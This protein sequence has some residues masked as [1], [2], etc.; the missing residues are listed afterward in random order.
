MKNSFHAL[1][2]ILLVKGAL[3]DLLNQNV[4]TNVFTDGI[5]Y[6]IESFLFV[7]VTM[8]K[9][10]GYL[11]KVASCEST[12]NKIGSKTSAVEPLNSQVVRW[13]LH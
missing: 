2:F 4:W 7:L 3:G 1:L 8:L 9:Q 5:I 11:Y 12:R 10:W 6:S 13:G